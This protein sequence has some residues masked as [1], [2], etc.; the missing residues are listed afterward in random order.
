[1]R[2]FI[3]KVGT[4]CIVNEELKTAVIRFKGN[5]QHRLCWDG[6]CPPIAPGQA[7]RV[8]AIKFMI[9]ENSKLV[10]VDDPGSKAVRDQ[11]ISEVEP[12]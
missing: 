9:S 1:M 8:S 11:F 12:V 6:D 3:G 7:V 5:Q 10:P 4:V 2:E